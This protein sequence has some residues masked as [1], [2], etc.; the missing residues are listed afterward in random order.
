MRR[1]EI[2][3]E[4]AGAKLTLRGLSMGEDAVFLLTGGAAHVGAVAAA[5]VAAGEPEGR[6]QGEAQLLHTYALPGH[7][8][9][10][11]AADLAAM[12]ASSLGCTVVVLAGIHLDRPTREEIED[13]VR[14]SKQAMREL[15]EG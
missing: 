1:W 15:L 10:P 9:G 4:S 6:R 12:A 8:E 14:A 11:L 3:R 13:V 2:E 7:R 5:S